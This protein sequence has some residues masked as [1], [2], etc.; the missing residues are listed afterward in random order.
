MFKFMNKQAGTWTQINQIRKEKS[1]LEQTIQ[2]KNDVRNFL[3][4]P[5]VQEPPWH[6]TYTHWKIN[7]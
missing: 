7:N 5:P 4:Y 1:N 3:L 6:M 2:L